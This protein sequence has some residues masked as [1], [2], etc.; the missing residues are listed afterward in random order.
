MTRLSSASGVPL[1]WLATGNGAMYRKEE[2]GD[3]KPAQDPASRSVTEPTLALDIE[4]LMA[5]IETA[6]DGLQASHRAVSTD[7]KAEIIAA[8][9]SLFSRINH[10]VLSKTE[11][12]NLIRATTRS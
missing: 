6:E 1:G 10:L 7:Q 8:I 2:D 11:V 5:A 3:E 9:Y 12:K 4:K